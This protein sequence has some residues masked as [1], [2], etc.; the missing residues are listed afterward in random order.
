ML[1]DATSIP[2]ADTCSDRSPQLVCIASGKTGLS[3]HSGVSVRHNPTSKES[4]RT[5]SGSDVF[6][7]AKRSFVMSQIRGGGNKDTE[8][9]MIALFRMYRF[10][11]W[12][13]GQK[14]IGK[15]DFVFRGESL[16][17]FVDGCFWHGCPK[18]KHAPLP[19]TRT[20]WWAAKLSRN[21]ARDQEVTRT[22]RRQGWR[23]IRV[24][25]CDLAISA[26]WPRIA[27]RLR[28]VL[29]SSSHGGT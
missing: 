25:E 6:T 15:P 23:V 22:L 8:L 16:A 17:V 9:R 3:Q 14:I 26:L 4:E 12:R 29:K 5:G 1:E 20:D 21:K 7:R 10:T 28:R 24:W 18:P 19:K 11:G 13:R 27:R 2:D